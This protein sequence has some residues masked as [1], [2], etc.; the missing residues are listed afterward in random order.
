M[1]KIEDI[2]NK[3]HGSEEISR[4]GF[5]TMISRVTITLGLMGQAVMSIRA[6]AP[7]VL[8]EPLKKFKIGVP[9]KYSDGANYLS[10]GRLFVIRKSQQY[11]S[12]SAICTHL[13]CTVNLVRLGSPEK[14]KTLRGEE[15]TQ[16]WE[17]HCP[18]HG[19]KYRGDGS[20]YA[21]PAPRDL[22]H[23][24]LALAPDGQLLV[25]TGDEVKKDERLKV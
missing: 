23:W 12:I 6:L 5:L 24:D 8:Y 20:V 13:G 18:C 19:S 14:V 2:V 3:K 10:S 21:G 17:F 15:I 4:G 22:H 11:H 16:E 7:N 1:S 25:D 9:G